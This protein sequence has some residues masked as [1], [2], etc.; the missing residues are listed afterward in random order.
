M[1]YP[2]YVQHFCQAA[3]SAGCPDA[4][5]DAMAGHTNRA[6]AASEAARS[7]LPPHV[8]KHLAGVRDINW[9]IGHTRKLDSDRLCAS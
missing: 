2:D 6:S 5:A 7:S 9:L 4:L 1:S 8:I 3:R